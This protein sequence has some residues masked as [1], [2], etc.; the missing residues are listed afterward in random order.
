MLN[1]A[2]HGDTTIENDVDK[3]RDRE[4][5]GDGCKSGVFSERVP[6]EGRV[7]LYQ[8]L[9]MHVIERSLLRNDLHD[10]RDVCELS[11]K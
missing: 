8:T 4:K 3:A 2:L 1:S 6:R 9:G 5:V 10:V 7:A 11:S